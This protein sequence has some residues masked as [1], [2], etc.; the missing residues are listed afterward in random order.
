MGEFSCNLFRINVYNL[1]IAGIY[2]LLMGLETNFT[3]SIMAGHS[4]II[5]I[6]LVVSYLV[7]LYLAHATLTQHLLTHAM[8]SFFIY[9][10]TINYT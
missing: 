7:M 5:W 9:R 6:E 10:D 1:C 8:I 2:N 4:A 3:T